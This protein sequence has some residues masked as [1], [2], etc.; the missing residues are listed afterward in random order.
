MIPPT[1][2][3]Q[4]RKEAQLQYMKEQ[5]YI[6]TN[7]AY[8][9]KLLELDQEAMAKEVPNNLWE[10]FRTMAA[11]ETTSTGSEASSVQNSSSGSTS[12]SSSSVLPS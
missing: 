11:G 6:Q 12:S 5:R 3:E 7:K 2:L 4:K 1:Y 10:A 8:F 9:E